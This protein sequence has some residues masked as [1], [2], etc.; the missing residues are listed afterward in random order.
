[1]KN[2]EMKRKMIKEVGEVIKKEMKNTCLLESKSVFKD[3][4]LSQNSHLIGSSVASDINRTAPNLYTLLYSC[5][6]NDERKDRS[7][8]VIAGILLHNYSERANLVQRLFSTILYAS[9]CPK[10]VNFWCLFN[11][12][13]TITF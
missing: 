10:Q 6:R 13:F 12:F 5:T 1:M 7:I 8:V 2:N 3:K 9:H 11:S 4:Q